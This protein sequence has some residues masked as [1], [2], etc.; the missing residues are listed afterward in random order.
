MGLSL[1]GLGWEEGW[2]ALGA[3]AADLTLFPALTELHLW[4][5]FDEEL[6]GGA[7][8]ST[9][10]SISGLMAARPA[11][12]VQLTAASGKY[13]ATPNMRKMVVQLRQVVPDPDRVVMRHVLR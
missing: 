7:A 12:I 4:L 6:V 11:L 13:S 8:D 9:Y 2:R 10:D 1:T 3:V 5:G